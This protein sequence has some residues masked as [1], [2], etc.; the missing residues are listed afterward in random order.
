[1]LTVDMLEVSLRRRGG[2]IVL[3]VR[4]ATFEVAAGETLALVG[5]SGC[6][7]SMTCLALA[8]LL[9]RRAGVTGGA[10]VLDGVDLRETGHRLAATGLADQRQRLAR[11]DL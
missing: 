6:G 11:S 4:D 1:M 8:G 7:K 9:P 3:P 2:D 10:V 5:E